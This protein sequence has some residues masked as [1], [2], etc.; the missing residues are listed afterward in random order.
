MADLSESPSSKIEPQIGE[1]ALLF[2]KTLLV[3][4]LSAPGRLHHHIPAPAKPAHPGLGRGQRQARGTG[5][6][7]RIAAG[8]Q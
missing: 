3:D 1:S 2:M 6:I 8:S 7:H 4:L 5:R